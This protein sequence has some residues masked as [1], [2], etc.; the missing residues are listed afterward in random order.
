[1]HLL[2]AVVLTIILIP[3]CG[4]RVLNFPVSTSNRLRV[5]FHKGQ[6]QQRLHTPARLRTLSI[7]DGNRKHVSAQASTIDIELQNLND[8][9]YYGPITVGTPGQQLNV[10]FDTGSSANWIFSKRC[11][12]SPDTRVPRKY[13]N[14][15]ST[16]YKSKL[17]R[18]AFGYFTKGVSG[19]WAEDNISVG[20]L[21][22]ENQTFGLAT[23]NHGVYEN[24]DIDGMIGL[25]FFKI[26]G[27]K[28]PNLF[29]NMVRQGVLQN[30]VFSFYFNRKDSDDPSSRL[31]L[32]GTNPDLYTGDFTF[33]N[34]TSPFRWHFEGD[35]VQLYGGEV[36]FSEN[37]FQAVVESD[38]DMIVGPNEDVSVLNMKL[39]ATLLS[40]HGYRYVYEINC[41]SV[42]SLPDVE[43]VVNGKKLAL[44]SKDYVVKKNGRC[45]SAFTGKKNSMV[46]RQPQWILGT[47]FM[48]GFYTQFDK[49]S[50][51]I[52]FAK[53]K[54]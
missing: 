43:F 52:G 22:V 19:V 18:F 16:T 41:D 3:S 31:T 37:G 34:L 28:E 26:F 47:P 13:N 21:T 2:P 53:A 42:D 39:G 11:L 20:G 27:G 29:D 35:W 14:A 45:L 46:R 5:H 15:S 7:Q 54:H 33:A 30:P 24:V 9:M 1:M 32:G 17:L 51:R 36:K 48:R 23:V 49:G 25:G 10:A 38:N 8:T 4:A 50:G 44:S 40:Q 12:S 6:L